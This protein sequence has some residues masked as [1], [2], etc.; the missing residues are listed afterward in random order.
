MGVLNRKKTSLMESERHRGV[1]S[2]VQNARIK[3]VWYE[4]AVHEW[5]MIH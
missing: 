4:K 3:A 5:D 1:Y 2:I